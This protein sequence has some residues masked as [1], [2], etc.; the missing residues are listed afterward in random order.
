M[1]DELDQ[2]LLSLRL[3]RMREL[4]PRALDDAIAA[5]PSYED[6]LLPLLREQWRHQQARALDYRISEANLPENWTL[7]TFPYALQPGVH[8]P[9]IRQ[10][11]ALDWVAD[12]TNI[13]FHGRTGVGKTGLAMGLLRKALQNGYRGRFIK[14]QDLIDSMYQS[15]AHH[16][17]RKLLDQLLRLHVLAI[18]EL[19]YLALRQEQ[20]NLFFKLMSERYEKKRAT[21]ITTNLDYE[22]WYSVLGQ[23]NLVDALLN[24]VR[25][26]CQTIKIDGPSL[27]APR[28]LPDPA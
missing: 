6:F 1:K 5:G 10:L 14:A 23:K 20:Q 27:R 4:L 22:D 15:L 21:I 19:G 28:D 24:R 7:D 9:T 2:L 12:G 16:G 25:H 18:D 8:P 3:K 17:T 13:V 26:R 11:A